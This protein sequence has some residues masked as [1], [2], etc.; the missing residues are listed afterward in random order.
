[1]VS[2]VPVVEFQCAGDDATIS[3][4]AH[5]L[6]RNLDAISISYSRAGLVINISKTEV[7]ACRQADVGDCD[8]DNEERIIVDGDV[9]KNVP[10]FTYLTSVLIP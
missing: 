9:L 10:Q 3:H 8:A 5:G 6:Q 1:M 7:L 4:T 2:S